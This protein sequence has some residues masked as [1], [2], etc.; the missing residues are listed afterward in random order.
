VREWKDVLISPLLSIRE[1]IEKITSNA[2]QICLVVDDDK[3][4]IG[5]VTD[6]D[7]RCGILEGLP[8]DDSVSSIMNS[9]PTVVRQYEGKSSILDIMMKKKIHHI[10]VVDDQGCVLDLETLDDIVNPKKKDN[11][12]VLM[13]GG[14]G[15]RLKPLT[16]DCPKPMLKIAGKPILENI[17][18]NLI[19]YGFR[20]FFI[21]VNYKAD[22][23]TSYFGDGSRWGVEIQYIHE[24]Q[25]MGTAGALSNLPVRPEEPLLVMNADLITEVNYN[26]L[27][28]YHEQ[29]KAK[30]TMC[31]R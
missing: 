1:V 21:T 18:E 27:I 30:A 9:S 12:V 5:T 6:G 15:T 19:E 7:I 29:H 26:N 23:V 16:D 3:K 8:L 2:L 24:K 14:L 11:V 17:I 13:A 31:V 4:L 28:A 22:I 25:R 20:K 10:P